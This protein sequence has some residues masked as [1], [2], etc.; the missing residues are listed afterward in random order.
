M[1]ARLKNVARTL[2]SLGHAERIE[3]LSRRFPL[4]HMPE[5]DLAYFR[6][7]NFAALKAALE[8]LES[9]DGAEA[10]AWRG[11]TRRLLGDLV[12]G[13]RELEDA[14]RRGS[15]LGLTWL[16][17]LDLGRATGEDRL[18][19]AAARLPGDPWPRYYLGAS[20]LM[21]GRAAEAE[22]DFRLASRAGADGLLPRLL[23]GVAFEKMGEDERALA[24]Y[25]AATRAEPNSPAPH[26]MRARLLKDDAAAAR[27]TEDAFDAEPE[28]SHVAMYEY[29]SGS[30]PWPEYLRRLVGY[31]FEPKRFLSL[32]ARYLEVDVKILPYHFEY[33]RW[34]EELLKA[35][36]DRSWTW[37]L[38]GR[39]LARCPASSGLL[40]RGL[41]A[42]DRAVS[43]SPE[44]G[45]VYGWRGLG[46]IVN[47]RKP[48]ALK[49]LDEC[50]R[51]QPY[52]CWAYEWRGALLHSFG[53]SQEALVDL[54]RAVSTNQHYPFALNRR[55]IVRRAMGD[56][57]GAVLDLDEA[58][59]LDMRYAW[60]FPT[61]RTPEK[62]EIDNGI[63]EL[64]RAIR[65]EP[66]MPSLRAWRGQTRLQKRDYSGA[67]RDFEAGLALDP[68]HALT[69][70]W[71]G[72]GLTEAGRPAE[73]LKRLTRAVELAPD[74]WLYRL[75]RADAL[76]I[77][78]RAEEALAALDEILR[79]KP[80]SW[81]AWQSRARAALDLGRLR[82]G[83]R[84]ARKTI[85]LEGRNAD[86]YYLEAEA[87]LGLGR[88]AEAEETTDR[89]LAISRHH[90]RAW[91]LRAEI[92][93]RRGRAAEAVA[94]Y[95]HAL[96]NF[97]F[98]FNEE[99]TRNVKALLGAA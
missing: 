67:F 57:A 24:A 49:D 35:H 81:P 22:A 69:Q 71:Y 46:R 88:L 63:K 51:R 12:G 60:V 30:M 74:R 66:S 55:S 36:P 79:E 94:D 77:A 61:G 18:L 86:S 47:D 73:G 54:D 89:L 32:S 29:K 37:G 23:R 56:V 34:G 43:I 98:L 40:P 38:L 75:W 78:G 95:R 33:V 27:A 97:P 5:R 68:A 41:A 64:T 58:F 6:R 84:C 16:G 2:E 53:R 65:R 8:S 62:R 70:A 93:T 39:A 4:P 9:E 19:E 15:A 59:R 76:R 91:V 96:E 99:Q 14:A 26:L 87:L 25:A 20:R 17:E 52:Y 72:R 92:R 13:R 42:L 21:R 28:Y 45:W 83:L 80:R 7:V 11:R 90:P 31:A 1:S 44:R 48:E 50:V 10:F 3:D 85:S 82:E